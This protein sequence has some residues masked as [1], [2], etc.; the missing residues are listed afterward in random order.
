MN[1]HLVWF[2]QDLRVIDHKALHKACE[3][4]TAAVYG[5][6]IATPGQWRQHDVAPLRDQFIRLHVNALE[7]SLATINIPLIYLE[8]DSFSDIPEVIDNL[9][10]QHQFDTLFANREYGWNE[11][12]RDQAVQQV[13]ENSCCSIDLSDDQ[14]IQKPGLLTQTGK[15]YTVFTPYKKKWL[16]N[17]RQQRAWP[18]PAPKKRQPVP[19]IPSSPL[20][21]INPKP[22]LQAWPIGEPAALQQLNDF[23]QQR[24]GHYKK[25]RDLPAIDGTSS[26]SPWLSAGVLSPRQCLDAAVTANHGK[27][28]G[29]SEGVDTWISELIWR[30]FYIHILDSFPQV[31]KNKAFKEK[32]EN[33]HWRNNPDEFAAW[34][35]GRT[36]FPIIDAAMRQ[37]LATGWMHNRLRMIVAMFLSKH[38][39]IDWRWGERFFMQHLIDGHLAANNGGWQWAASTGTDAVPYFRIF[40]PVTQSQRFDRDGDFIRHYVPELSALDK[41]SIHMPSDNIRQHF[42][43]SY[44]A[45]IIDLKERRTLALEAFGGA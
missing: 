20:P 16:E 12:I 3:D 45:P 31:S 5:L 19:L 21:V 2:R 36:G 24:I 6:Y 14:A 11:K 35:E 34:C 28:S 40:N 32:T 1:K 23:C 29:G 30:D 25:H 26:L 22:Q 17:F 4:D 43:P 8:V 37:L 10:N 42:T 18:Q 38:L 39:L 15:P 27:L 44:P 41:K 9:I 33:I 7:K 13:L